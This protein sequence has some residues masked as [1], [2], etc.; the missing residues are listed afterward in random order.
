MLSIQL[1]LLSPYLIN[2][3]RV[4]YCASRE[5]FDIA[6]G[7]CVCE[8]V[9]IKYGNFSGDGGGLEFCDS[10]RRYYEKQD[11]KKNSSSCVYD[12]YFYNL[13][14]GTTSGLPARV[15]DKVSGCDFFHNF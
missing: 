6:T 3:F 9:V 2:L 8:C 11:R 7:V 1:G 13:V 12:L 10:K 5:N 4:P 15:R 14:V